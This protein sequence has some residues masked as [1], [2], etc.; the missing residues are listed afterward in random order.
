MSKVYRVFG[1][2]LLALYGIAERS[3]WEFAGDTVK[4]FVP[5]GSRSAGGY[6]TF[7]YWNGGK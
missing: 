1:I 6:R 4:G 2:L 3:G 5:P 7:H